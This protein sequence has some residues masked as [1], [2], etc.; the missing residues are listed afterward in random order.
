MFLRSGRQIQPTTMQ[1]EAAGAAGA[2]AGENPPNQACKGLCCASMLP[3]CF[4]L[5]TQPP[6]VFLAR[7]FCQ[8]GRR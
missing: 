3:L 2:E 4:L 1:A 5:I 6:A 7:S 8:S